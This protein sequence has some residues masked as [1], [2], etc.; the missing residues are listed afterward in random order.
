MDD[1]SSWR[2]KPNK[3]NEQ[4]LKSMIQENFPELKNYDMK[5][6]MGRSH[7]IP[8]NEHTDSK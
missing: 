3:T 2:R 5:L 1:R 4:V 8:E 7:C 6:G